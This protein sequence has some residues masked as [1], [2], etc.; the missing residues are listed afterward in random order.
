[1]CPRG[2]QSVTRAFFQVKTVPKD[3]T[4]AQSTPTPTKDY[5]TPFL[6]DQRDLIETL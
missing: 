5:T 2:V 6:K 4:V 3:M 1:M